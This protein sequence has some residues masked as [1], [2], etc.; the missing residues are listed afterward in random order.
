MDHQPGLL[1]DDLGNARM[2]VAEGVDA[3]A[4]E[5]V[6]VTAAFQVVNPATLAARQHQRIAGIVLQQVLFFQVHDL[7]GALRADRRES[8]RHLLM[9]TR[10]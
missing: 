8:G 9:I 5:Q 1:A 10:A 4:G 7:L 6:Q 3:D 2:R